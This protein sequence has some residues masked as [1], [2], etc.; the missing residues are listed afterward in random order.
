MSG[1]ESSGRRA[2]AGEQGEVVIQQPHPY[3]A[4]TV[5]QSDGFGTSAWRGNL[6]RWAR[7]FASGAGYVQGDAAVRYADGAYTFHGRSDEV[8]NVGGNRIG[9]EEIESAI[10]LDRACEGS[11]LLN[12]AVVGA[13]DVVLGTAPCAFLVL[14]PG[15]VLSSSDEIRIRATVQARVSSAAVPS[16]FVVVPALP[17]TYSGKYMRRLL[18]TIVAGEALGDLGALKNPECVQSLLD[19]IACPGGTTAFESDLKLLP[20]AQ[21]RRFVESVVL[22]IV[23]E[24]TGAPESALDADTALMQ[25][26]IDSIAATELASR[27]GSFSAMALSS[28]LVFEQPTPRAIAMQLTEPR[29][30]QEWVAAMRPA[31]T[32]DIDAGSQLALAAMV[33]CWPGGCNRELTRSCLLLASGDAV[34][35]V[36]HVRWVHDKVVDESELSKSQAACVLHGGFVSGAQCF[37][38]SAFGLSRAES[39]VTDPQQR[40]LLEC[41]YT[42]L[43]MS[44]RRRATLLGGDTGVFLGVERP[45]WALAQPRESQTSVYAVISDNVS[46]AAGRVSFTLGLHGPCSS[47]DTACSSALAALCGA[48][49][50][51]SSALADTTARRTRASDLV[52]TVS[53][54]L[55]PHF[56]LR[57]ASAGMLS[58]D[59]RCKTLDVRANGYTRSE[60]VGALVLQP[61]NQALLLCGRALRQDGRSASLT[62]PNGMAQQMLLIVALGP[63]ATTVVRCVEAHGTGT[64][65]GDP[66]EMAAIVAV[67]R[68]QKLPLEVGAGKASVGHAEAAA[69]HVGLLKARQ[70]INEEAA[71][72]NAQLRTLN[73]VVEGRLGG[74]GQGVVLPMHHALLPTASSM[75]VS[76]F[77]FSGTIAHAVLAIRQPTTPARWLPNQFRRRTFMWVMTDQH[78]SSSSAEIGPGRRSHDI[79]FL[80]WT[81]ETLSLHELVWE[82]QLASH[83]LTFL[84]DHCVGQV[85]LLPGTCYI[86]MARAMVGGVH[87]D[88]A[89]ALL[90]VQFTSIL[91][92]DD[93]FDAAP[94]VRKTLQRSTGSLTITSRR[95]QGSSWDT[96]SAMQLELRSEDAELLDLPVIQTRC[97]EHVSGDK[98]YH[99]CGNHYKGEFKAMK[100]AWGRAG[101]VEILSKISYGHIETNYVHLR[102]C[103]WLDTCLHAPYWW[104]DHRHRPFYIASV[105]SYLIRTNDHSRNQDMWSQMQGFGGSDGMQPDVLKY[106]SDELRCRV[107]IDGSRLGFFD[108]GWL[109]NRRVRKDLY[110]TEWPL[111]EAPIDDH[112]TPGVDVGAVGTLLLNTTVRGRNQ[113]ET[114]STGAPTHSVVVGHVF[115]VLHSASRTETIALLGAALALLQA[116]V[117]ADGAP[118]LMFLTAR[119]YTVS[120]NE[121]R[122]GFESQGLWELARSARQE[123]QALCLQSVE[124]SRCSSSSASLERSLL[125][126]VIGV[127]E[128]EL[129]QLGQGWC[130]PKLASVGSLR[131]SLQQLHIRSRGAISDLKRVSQESS[132][133]ALASKEVELQV[134]A[135]GLNFR[136]VLNVLGEY[137][138][139]PGPPGLD[140]CGVIS[141]LKAAVHL[142]LGDHAFGF[143][144]GCLASLVITDARLLVRKP[145]C[146][147]ISQASSLPITWSTVH[148]AFSQAALQSNQVSMLH[149]TAGGVGLISLEYGWVCG[150]RAHATAG[151]ISKHRV[152]RALDQPIAHSSRSG[153]TIC[154]S[155]PGTLVDRLLASVLNSRCASHRRFFIQHVARAAWRSFAHCA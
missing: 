140:C 103:A 123:S 99:V 36:P 75:G 45:D 146:L 72:G 95:E 11:P 152:V 98:F 41:S 118:K 39:C 127:T 27:L 88:T 115:A 104:S 62:A 142:S 65:L 73:V 113:G 19:A 108:V 111:I 154:V 80:G 29:A 66:T 1:V 138:G 126:L 55:V 22:R 120:T 83:E 112:R 49:L 2:A 43:H 96:H 137:P 52:L 8:M 107:Q 46:V 59:G 54:K 58:V 151:S 23:Q 35:G 17:E 145:A 131:S 48:A 97:S 87:G 79:P 57:A 56:T 70:S 13:D 38:G 78:D 10:L 110:T 116:V 106:H 109:E 94:T 89:F 134:Q 20:T 12:C 26:G 86:E 143:A 42:S 84:Q 63:M 81:I 31:A 117:T 85:A 136:D 155:N 132:S 44:T 101:G 91:F 5:W 102:S 71:G 153:G 34:G 119:E 68:A 64:R 74:T 3:L 141:Q 47:V 7:Y 139:C 60:A 121:H 130:T 144:F 135:V 33:G 51:I 25:A 28:T 147:T 93:E 90:A 100:D 128:P 50:D 24:L 30:G 69:G 105:T 129:V 16:R 114:I 150:A 149:T 21:R 14:R 40:L 122:R 15:S 4:L 124:I 9:T 61:E 6:Q 76:A 148:V 133:K 32:A 67:Y 125:P 53:L 82:Q 77:G 18:R 37:D 92:L